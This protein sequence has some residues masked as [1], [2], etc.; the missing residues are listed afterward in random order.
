MI[1]V[2]EV[3]TDPDFVRQFTVYR[4][5]G[6]WVSGRWTESTPEQIVMTGVISVMSEKELQA[7]PEGDKIK[8]AM[9]FHSLQELFV[10]RNGTEKGTSDKI[11]WRG[12]YYRLFNIAPYIDYGYYRAAGE[13]ITGN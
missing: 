13:R 11:L 12:D 2:S 8:G 3:I 10:T 9:V 7:M 6:D 1:N 5:S 4:S